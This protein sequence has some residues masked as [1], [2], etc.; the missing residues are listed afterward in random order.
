MPHPSSLLGI[1]SPRE[2]A[3]RTSRFRV[4]RTRFFT[5]VKVALHAR[6]CQAS[7]TSQAVA[8][9]SLPRPGH[10]PTVPAGRG[11]P[12]HLRAGGIYG[13]A[14]QGRSVSARL[15]P[16]GPESSAA[17]F[18]PW[19]NMPKGP[20]AGKHSL[21][22]HWASGLKGRCGGR[23]LGEWHS[24]APAGRYSAKA[25]LDAARGTQ[26]HR[27]L[28]R[29]PLGRSL[30]PDSPTV[31]GFLRRCAGQA[32]SRIPGRCQERPRGALCSR[33]S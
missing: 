9:G 7:F 27:L 24:A 31:S 6:L 17:G 21:P 10:R 5:N 3:S 20:A 33:I 12:P 16:P 26:P 23:L 14:A 22:A 29:T 11:V 19:A 4:S 28:C 8:A 25:F 2:A 1:R 18:V 15:S 30:F 13:Q 32:H